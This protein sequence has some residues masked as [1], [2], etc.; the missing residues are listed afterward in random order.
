M[1]Q[2]KKLLTARRQG[3]YTFESM[4]TANNNGMPVEKPVRDLLS[5]DEEK[6]SSSIIS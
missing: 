2:Q 4:L 1:M 3:T 6:Y 5:S